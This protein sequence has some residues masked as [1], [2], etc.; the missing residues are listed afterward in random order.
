V[1]NG[2]PAGDSWH[3]IERV[4]DYWDDGDELP[5]APYMELPDVIPA[6]FYELSPVHEPSCACAVDAPPAVEPGWAVPG[7]TWDLSA[8]A[9]CSPTPAVVA[10]HR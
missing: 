2:L 3:I 10:L 1:H 5:D 7:V 8:A 9:P 4:F 6:W